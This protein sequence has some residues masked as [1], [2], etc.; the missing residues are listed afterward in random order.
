MYLKRLHKLSQNVIFKYYAPATFNGL[1]LASQEEYICVK[2]SIE[3]SGNNVRTMGQ[4]EQNLHHSAKVLYHSRTLLGHY[5]KPII[6]NGHVYRQM[7]LFHS[8]NYFLFFFTLALPGN[9]QFLECLN[10]IGTVQVHQHTHIY[11]NVCHFVY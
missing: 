9:F 7:Q 2:S 5:T 3:S 6:I 8:G 4:S 11:M 10:Y 1:I